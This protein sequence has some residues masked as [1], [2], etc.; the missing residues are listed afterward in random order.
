VFHSIPQCLDFIN[1]IFTG[2]T[3]FYRGLCPPSLYMLAHSYNGNELNAVTPRNTVLLQKSIVTQLANKFPAFLWNPNVHYCAKRSPPLVPIL[4]QMNQ[5]HTFTPYFFK[6]YFYMS[7][8]FICAWISQVVS[9]LQVLQLKFSMHFS[10][11]PCVPH[12]THPIF[13]DFITRIIFSGH[14][15]VARK[16]SS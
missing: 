14:Y 8:T 12:P 4:N 11:P 13:L 9:S 15:N 5:V 3:D 1:K 16:R 6:I 2:W 7:N 10:F